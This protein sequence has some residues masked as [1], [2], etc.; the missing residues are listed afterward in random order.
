MS[1]GMPQTT[2][3][4]GRIN[5]AVD[6]TLPGNP[7]TAGVVRVLRQVAVEGCRRRCLPQ[8]AALCAEHRHSA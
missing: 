4:R 2:G 5:A 1:Y 3:G 8:N 6:P 7:P